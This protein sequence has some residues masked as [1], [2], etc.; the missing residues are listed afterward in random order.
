MTKACDEIF[1]LPTI[2][3]FIY[4]FTE[5]KNQSNHSE[6]KADDTALSGDLSTMT[7]DSVRDHLNSTISTICSQTTE[8]IVGKLFI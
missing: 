5:L 4:Y 2:S 6:N 8:E 3:M 7:L 1:I